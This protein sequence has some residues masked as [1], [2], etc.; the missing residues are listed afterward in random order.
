M[1]TLTF[2]GRSIFEITIMTLLMRIWINLFM[3]DIYNSFSQFIILVTQPFITPIKFF[4]PNIKNFEISSFI[5]LSII[6]IMKYPILTYLEVTFV[7]YILSLT[8]Y[9]F[10]GFFSLVKG[11]GYLI[12]WLIT[13]RS[14]FSWFN[15]NYNDFDIVLNKLTD[16]ILNFT[17]KYISPIYNVDMS[18]FIITMSLYFLNFL[19]Y[20]LFPGF[21]S[22]I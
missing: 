5:L 7:P 15:R 4:I 17:R 8:T 9:I 11:I 22:I 18:A 14:I 2:L 13:I 6:C 16:Q 10:I 19:G 12:F 3:N 1:L 21:W 20:D